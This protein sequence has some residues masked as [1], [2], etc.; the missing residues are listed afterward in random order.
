MRKLQ[1]QYEFNGEWFDIWETEQ[2]FLYDAWNEMDVQ[3]LESGWIRFDDNTKE[4]L[5]VNGGFIQTQ[6]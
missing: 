4:C 2:E 5:V 3:P 1:M 6:W